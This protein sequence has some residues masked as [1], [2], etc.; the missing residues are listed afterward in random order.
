MGFLTPD[1]P[2]VRKPD[3]DPKT[4][5]LIQSYHDQSTVDEPTLVQKSLQGTDESRGLLEAGTPDGTATPG[6]E[7]AGQAI[8]KRAQ[9]F[10]DRGQAD[11][12]RSAEASAPTE[13][14]NRLMQNKQLL[15]AEQ[16]VANN[17]YQVLY[18]RYV[19]QQQARNAIIRSIAG[20]AG[21]VGGAFLGGPPGA[22]AGA[23]ALSTLAG[24]ATPAP[25]MTTADAGAFS[26]E[27][28]TMR[29]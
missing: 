13:R 8:R 3:L 27:R 17:Y 16:K 24:A 19:A 26:D 20:V 23:A 25:D 7:L 18:R 22:M 15:A 1:A 4:Q 10:Y 28:G 12:R 9:S 2:E 29:S 5:E 6:D 11:M 21:A 14:F